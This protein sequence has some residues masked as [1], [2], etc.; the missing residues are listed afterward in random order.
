MLR[1]RVPVCPVLSAT[2]GV[3][4]PNGWM[5]QMP[6]GTE[7]GLGPCDIILDGGPAPPT[8]RGTAALTFRPCLLWPNGRTPQQ[9]LSFCY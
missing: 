6:L 2:L 5:D 7:A 8:E 3:L 4:W 9:L 1:D